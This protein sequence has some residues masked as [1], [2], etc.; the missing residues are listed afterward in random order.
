MLHLQNRWKGA[1]AYPPTN[2]LNLSS[3]PDYLKYKP[4]F[5]QIYNNDSA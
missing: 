3:Q 5:D 1:H 2:R 4:L